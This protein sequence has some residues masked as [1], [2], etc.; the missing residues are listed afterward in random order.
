MDPSQKTTTVYNTD[1]N[2]LCGA[3]YQSDGVSRPKGYLHTPPEVNA[4]RE[5]QGT[6]SL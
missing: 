6:G 5:H 1:F 4:Q 3:Q 2:G